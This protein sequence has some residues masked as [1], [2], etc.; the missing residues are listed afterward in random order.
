[1]VEQDGNWSKVSHTLGSYCILN[2]AQERWC[3]ES[4]PPQTS[5]R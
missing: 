3:Q 5:Q 4:R 2:H 1:L